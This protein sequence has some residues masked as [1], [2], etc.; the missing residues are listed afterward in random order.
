MNKRSGLRI[1][2]H[3][4][5]QEVKNAIIRFSKWLRQNYEFPI[6]LPVY[7]RPEKEL[8][9]LSGNKCSASFFAPWSMDEEPYI[10]IAT[11]CYPSEKQE[12]GRDNALAGYLSSLAHEIVHYQQWVKNNKLY[13]HGVSA[14]ASIMVDQYATTTDSP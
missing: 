13:E 5:N 6:R 8:T 11:G 3:R 7:L 2:G 14:K 4:G 9:N 12:L 1:R 10:R